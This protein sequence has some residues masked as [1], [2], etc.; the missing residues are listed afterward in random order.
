MGSPRPGYPGQMPTDP[1]GMPPYMPPY[2]YDFMR[3]PGTPQPHYNT[4]VGIQANFRVSYPIRVI[5][6]VNV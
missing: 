5:T 6:R 1:K 4:I 3:N 2:Y